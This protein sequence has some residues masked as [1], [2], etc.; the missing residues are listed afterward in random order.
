MNHHEDI[1]HKRCHKV[2]NT[3]CDLY[4]IR[5]KNLIQFIILSHLTLTFAAEDTSSKDF[6]KINDL[7]PSTYYLVQERYVSCKGRYRGTTYDGTEESKVL[8]PKGHEIAT[9]CTR[10]YKHLLMEGSGRLNK[11]G[12]K[13]YKTVSWAG[14]YKFKKQYKCKLG[15]AVS[16]KYCLLSHYSIAADNKHHKIGD[17]IYIPDA[18]GLILPDGSTH[19]GYFIVLDTGGSFINIGNQRVDLFV[20]LERDYKNIFKTAGFNHQTPIKAFKVTGEKRKAFLNN[21]EVKFG[22]QFSKNLFQK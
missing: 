3:F 19:K 21:L 2:D 18:D 17:V 15:T 10:F 5:M 13:S 7:L 16:P 22:K 12:R 14:N 20:G 9:V 1:N 6:I 11:R 4:K 8:D